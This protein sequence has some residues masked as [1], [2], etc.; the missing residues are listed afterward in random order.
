MHRDSLGVTQVSAVCVV[1]TRPR[2]IQHC[3]CPV[4]KPAVARGADILPATGV[5]LEAA[6]ERGTRG[7]RGTV[8]TYK[9]ERSGGL[10]LHRHSLPLP[11][12]QLTTLGFV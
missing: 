4:S 8:E 6:G 9:N 12:N 1:R 11:P 3:P 10:P 7:G 5:L 2:T